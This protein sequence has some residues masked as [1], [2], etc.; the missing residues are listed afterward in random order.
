MRISILPLIV[1]LGLAGCAPRALY[2]H[3][4]TKVG[5]SAD[6]NTADSQ[7][8]STNF[9]FKRRIVA[10]VPSQD[11]RIQDGGSERNATNNGEALSLVSKF[12]VRAGTSEGI[13]IVNN[14]ASGMAA[15]IMTQSAGASSNSLNAVMHSA[16]IAVSS[17]SGNVIKDGVDSGKPANEA[18]N[19]RLARIKTKKVS[20]AGLPQ[21]TTDVPMPSKPR[22]ATTSPVSPALP[23]PSGEV[24]MPSKSTTKPSPGGSILP[25]PSGEVPMPKKP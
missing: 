22:K 20:G 8:I 12:S 14:F 23:E 7:P 9:G 17:T 5:F 19:E 2:F 10:V 18:V 15:R 1:A 13:A 6:Y 24:P 4:T 3:E 16:P 25:V 11:R 21:P